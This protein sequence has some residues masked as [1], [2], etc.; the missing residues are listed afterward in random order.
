MTA[1]AIFLYLMPI[2][3]VLVVDFDEFREMIE[4]AAADFIENNRDIVEVSNIAATIILLLWP[5]ALAVITI[6][7]IW[8]RRHG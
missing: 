1:I 2:L 7:T 4:D 8:E 5:I 3:Y 6:W